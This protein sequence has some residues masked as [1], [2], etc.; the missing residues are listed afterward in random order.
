MDTILQSLGFSESGFVI[1]AKVTDEDVAKRYAKEIME[2]GDESLMFLILT[3][4]A[5]L[6]LLSLIGVVLKNVVMSWDI[7]GVFDRMLLQMVLCSVLVVVNWPIYQG[8]FFRKDGGKMPG[9]LMVK[10]LVL[11][12]SA[13]TCFMFLY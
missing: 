5:L 2:F 9:S 12:L 6:N 1:S 8:L 4:L 7:V 13:C 11:A 10:S 3:T